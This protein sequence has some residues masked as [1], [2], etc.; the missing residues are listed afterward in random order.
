MKLAEVKFGIMT[1]EDSDKLEASY[2]ELK[3]YNYRG[4]GKN[5]LMDKLM[6]LPDDAI[7]IDFCVKEGATYY[8][9]GN[10]IAY[11]R[12]YE[13]FDQ[14]IAL[15][16]TN[17]FMIDLDRLFFSGY[18]GELH[19]LRFIDETNAEVIGSEP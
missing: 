9:D 2:P 4:V 3:I 8:S 5:Y 17:T 7:D 16:T 11:S 19:I 15:D 1:V 13:I 10:E 6:P 14:Y 18:K 12:L